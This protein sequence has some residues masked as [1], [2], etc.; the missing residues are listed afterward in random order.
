MRRS[1]DNT[2]FRDFDG[3]G[4]SHYSLCFGRDSKAGGGVGK[5][6]SGERG[7]FR[8]ALTGGW[9]ARSRLIR[10]SFGIGHGNVFGFLWLEAGTKT[11]EAL[12]N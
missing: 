8:Y 2:L 10:A 9:G 4:V 6:C 12:S 3:K 5:L 7:G 11:R 1:K